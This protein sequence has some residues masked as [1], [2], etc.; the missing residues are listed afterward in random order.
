MAEMIYLYS[1]RQISS[2]LHLPGAGGSNVVKLPCLGLSILNTFVHSFFDQ[3]YVHF[4]R[5]VKAIPG[6]LAA[7]VPPPPLQSRLSSKGL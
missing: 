4:R 5:S 3:I 6:N 1:V 2:A 7:F